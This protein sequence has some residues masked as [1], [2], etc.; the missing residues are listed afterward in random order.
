MNESKSNG[1]VSYIVVYHVISDESE[2]ESGENGSEEL[3]HPIINGTQD[4]D[5]AADKSTKR[6]GGIHVASR[7]MHACRYRRK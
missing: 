3:S 5:P 6:D 7:Y 1:G 4:G 2:Q